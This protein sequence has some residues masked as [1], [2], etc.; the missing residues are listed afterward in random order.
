MKTGILKQNGVHLQDH[1]YATVKYFLDRGYDVILIPAVQVKGMKTPDIEFD[2]I[3][4]EMKSPTGGSDHTIKHNLSRAKKQSR[5][6]IVDLRRC[7]LPEDQAIKDLQH[8]FELSKRFRR[9]KIIKKDENMLDYK[10]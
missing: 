1:E 10:K 3:V 8:H 5:N 7:K 2:G 9:M 6:I 4:W